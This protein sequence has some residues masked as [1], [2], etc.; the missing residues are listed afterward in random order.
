MKFDIERT[1]LEN[2]KLLRT[3]IVRRGKEAALG[4]QP[5]Q[6]QRWLEP[7]RTTGH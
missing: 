5:E 6:W 7:E 3:P 1:L 4:P 2:P